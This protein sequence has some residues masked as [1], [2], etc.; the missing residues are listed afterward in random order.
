MDLFD[1]FLAVIFYICKANFE[2]TFYCDMTACLNRLP[3]REVY[4]FA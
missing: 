2:A 1:L 4:Q 3:R